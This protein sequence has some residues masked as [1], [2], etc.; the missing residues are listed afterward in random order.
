MR[1]VS[2]DP[3]I[4]QVLDLVE[5]HFGRLFGSR[6]TNINNLETKV[7]LKSASRPPMHQ[8]HCSLHD[9]GLWDLVLSTPIVQRPGAVR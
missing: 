7:E 6:P 9:P 1:R 8:H 4:R 2:R 5:Y 3:D